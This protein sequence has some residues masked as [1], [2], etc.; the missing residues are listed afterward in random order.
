MEIYEKEGLK[1]YTRGEWDRYVINVEFHKVYGR[2]NNTI[3]Q[4][5]K[6]LYD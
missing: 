2:T 6:Y 1:F 4:L 5:N 3:E